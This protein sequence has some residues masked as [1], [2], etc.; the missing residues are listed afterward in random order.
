MTV[1]KV[2]VLALGNSLIVS[3]A[4]HVRGKL[5]SDSQVG[6][7]VRVDDHVRL[8]L[9]GQCGGKAGLGAIPYRLVRDF[10]PQVAVLQYGANEIAALMSAREAALN[11]LRVA[12]ELM[13]LGVRVVEIMTILPRRENLRLPHWRFHQRAHEFRYWIRRATGNGEKIFLHVHK[14]FM[15]KL[16]KGRWQQVPMEDWSWD[17]IH[18][19]RPLGRKLYARSLRNAVFHGL[20]KL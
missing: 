2:P 8:K 6:A 10:K 20:T 7:Y 11:V 18:P 4:D 13:R 14:G 12:R 16:V 5:G 17:G 1:E 19:N 9:E 15:N 3:L